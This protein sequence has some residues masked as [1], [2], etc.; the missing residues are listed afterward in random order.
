[1]SSPSF[2]HVGV[3]LG[4]TAV[5]V[6]IM[7]K[8]SSGGNVRFLNVKG[9]TIRIR[10]IGDGNFEASSWGEG[11]AFS[12][13]PSTEPLATYTFGGGIPLSASG[14]PNVI[15]FLHRELP[16]VS[17]KNLFGQEGSERCARPGCAA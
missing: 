11:I 14:N 8:A 2:V 12:E 17:V 7:A 9:T 10:K 13:I 4:L 16:G 6:A 1:M 3:G 5:L 15:A